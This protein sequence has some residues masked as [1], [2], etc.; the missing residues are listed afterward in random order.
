MCLAMTASAALAQVATTVPAAVPCKTKL[1]KPCEQKMRPHTEADK[2]QFEAKMNKERE[3]FHNALNLTPEQKKKADELHKK[4]MNESE[5]LFKKV[6]EERTKFVELTAKNAPKEEILKQEITVKTA[7]KAVK[8]HFKASRKQFEAIL[9][10]EQL[11]KLKILKE[12]RKTEMKKHKKCECGKCGKDCKCD[13]CNKC[14]KKPHKTH[15]TMGRDGGPDEGPGGHPSLPLSGN[16][17]PQGLAPKCN[18]E[19]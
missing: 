10:K 11:A 12:Q 2:K 9:T 5:P 16:L 17:A 13:K 19:K 3:L 7:K 1:E 14:G 8:N 15:G 18:C 4:A 6:Q